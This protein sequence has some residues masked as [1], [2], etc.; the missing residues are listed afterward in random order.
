MNKRSENS[1]IINK[2]DFAHLLLSNIDE[3]KQTL[4]KHLKIQLKNRTKRQN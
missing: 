4:S 2:K 3:I 1:C